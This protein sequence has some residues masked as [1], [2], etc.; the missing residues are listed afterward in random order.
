MRSTPSRRR[1]ASHSRLIESGFSTCRGGAMGSCSSQTSPHFV[2]I[3][4]RLDSGSSRSSRPTISSECPSPY[5]A[6]VSIQLTPSSIACRIVASDSASSCGP[7]P[8]DQP[9]PPTAHEP[10]PTLVMSSPLVPSGRVASAIVLPPF[11]SLMQPAGQLPFL[12]RASLRDRNGRR[13]VSN[14]CAPLY[15]CSTASASACAR[16]QT[17]DLRPRERRL[18][19]ALPEIRSLRSD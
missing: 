8:N 6:A 11:E 19:Q 4:G 10:N 5:T 14:G 7:Q 16:P 1:D 13:A 9:P 3:N 15:G 17:S 2:K 18:L 12:P